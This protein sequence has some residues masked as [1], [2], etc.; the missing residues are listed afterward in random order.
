MPAMQASAIDPIDTRQIE[1][2]SYAP[3]IG[4]CRPG[5][6]E[7]WVSVEP[8][9]RGML[10]ADMAHVRPGF[11]LRPGKVQRPILPHETLRRDRL[12]DWLDKRSGKRVLLLLA[13]AGF[14]KTTLVA[15]HTRRSR[16]RTFWYR[17]DEDD[18]EGLVFIRYLVASCQAVDRRLLPRTSSVLN[19]SSIEPIRLEMVLDTLL[20]ELGSLGD[21]PSALVLDDFH[22]VEGI[23]SIVGVV[24]RLIDRAP[25]GLTVVVAGRHSPGFSLAALR[26]CG[27]VAELGREDLRFDSLEIG[28]LFREAY[29]HPLDQDVLAELQART[30][31]WVASLQLVKAA[32]EGMSMAQVR[33]FVRSLSAAEGDLYDF[34]AEEV[35]G[36]LDPAL[37]EFLLRAALLEEMDPGT[38]S[39]AGGVPPQRARFLLGQAERIGLLCRGEGVVGSWRAHPL[40]REFLLARLELELGAARITE[41]HRLL[42][43]ALEPQS[44]RLAARHWAAAGDA[45]EVKRVICGAVPAIMGTGDFA[46]AEDLIARFPDSY[47]N[48]WYDII[49]S[50]QL[51]AQGRYDEAL[52]LARRAAEI[53]AAVASDDPS[54]LAA[55]ALNRLH[56]GFVTGN[57]YLRTTASAELLARGDEELASIATSVELIAAASETGSLASLCRVLTDTAILNRL[58][59]HP[60]HEG[61]SHVNLSMT[62]LAAGNPM[63]ALRA[64]QD[65]LRLLAK[66][67]NSGDIAA[68][69][70]N[71]ARALAQLGRAGDWRHYAS[72]VL[73]EEGWAEPDGL[74]EMAELEAFYGHPAEARHVIDAAL[75]RGGWVL[76]DSTRRLV[77]ARVEMLHGDL[78]GA[79]AA[80][81]NIGPQ[82]MVPGFRRATSSLGLQIRAMEDPAGQGLLNDLAS[83]AALADAQQA[84]F[85]SKS[86]RLTKALVSPAQDL[87]AH[88]TS[89]EPEDSAYLSIQ[90]ELVVRRIGDLEPAS[91]GIVHKE[92]ALRPERWRWAV[93]QTMPRLSASSLALK[94]AVE[95]LEL[96]GDEQDVKVLRGFAKNK[97]LKMPD[98][99]RPLAR[100]L[101]PKAFVDDLGR[102][103]MRIGDREIAGTDIRKKVL[104]L[105]AYLLTR[106]QY[107]ASREQVIE[108]LWPDMEPEQGANSLNQTAY[109]L[110]QMFEPKSDDDSSA[111]YLNC[112]GDLIWL[113]QELVT[114]RSSACLKL[115]AASRRDDSPELVTELAEA[116]T[117]R[118]AADFLYDDWACAFR[119]TLHASY[120]DRVER[121]IQLDTRNGEFDRAIAVAQLALAADPD[122]DQIELCL[123]RLYRQIGAHAAAAEQYTHYASVLRD[124]LGVEPPPL[125]SI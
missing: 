26:A 87:V 15:D 88:I 32:V 99:G 101:A 76:P 114:S 104:S 107:T 33:E 82:Y 69:H 70:A 103:Q 50:R 42:A 94:R 68:A 71:I 59:G 84:W 73:A 122:A 14:G 48:P 39:V 81:H 49:R 24:E 40:V 95:L 1:F 34:L 108:A 100:R 62:E 115:I 86:I 51:A 77:Q 63:A 111:G 54:F 117:G 67:G 98:A 106:P 30:D 47:P 21:V 28:R 18:T 36:D 121:S 72:E 4:G 124:Q 5:L 22:V 78:S 35:V 16:L 45:A 66:A 91:L 83:E 92:A 89:L 61:I 119:E 125:E 85:W 44:W 79:I 113:D 11:P 53:G 58:A 102:I 112:R 9:I 52:S 105:L 75:A 93:R 57:R 8:E 80:I 3:P 20:T 96:V 65:A 10:A 27:E 41:L 97:Q 13:E 29:N 7:S 2:L 43:V 23:P 17:L 25:R 118:F 110:R 38:A 56:L 90:A 12:L 19:E 64:G 46:A 60:R 109:F 31:G 37:R 6:E 55:D 123:L 74:A 116:Y 120:L